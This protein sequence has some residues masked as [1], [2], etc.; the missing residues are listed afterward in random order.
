[1]KAHEDHI[2]LTSTVNPMSRAR[3][4]APFA[5][6]PLSEP[7]RRGRGQRP[8]PPGPEPR[9]DPRGCRIPVARCQGFEHGWSEQLR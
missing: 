9:S 3:K 1:M 8:C 5:P 4:T 6:I 7:Q 2:K